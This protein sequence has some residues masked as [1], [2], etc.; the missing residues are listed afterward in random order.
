MVLFPLEGRKQ[1]FNIFFEEFYDRS[2]GI[3]VGYN[4][5]IKRPA[6]KVPIAIGNKKLAGGSGAHA[7]DMIYEP[8]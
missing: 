1:M 8:V 4:I 5:K 6:Y 3:I 2:Q 7:I